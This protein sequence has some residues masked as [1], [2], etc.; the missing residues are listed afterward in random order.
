M[1]IPSNPLSSSLR[2]LRF[3]L[4]SS[5][6]SS[7]SSLDGTFLGMPGWLVLTL[8]IVLG[9]IA[10][11]A[12]AALIYILAR[13]KKIKALEQEK[14]ANAAQAT[15]L[16][17]IQKAALTK[18]LFFSNVSHDMR[19]PL[20][21][22]IGYAKLSENE[23]DPEK[24]ADYFKK[25]ENAG[26]LLSDLLN[27]TM[28]LSKIEAGKIE[29]RPEPIDNLAFFQEVVDEIQPAAAAKQIELR[30][31][32]DELVGRTIMADRLDLQKIMLNLL[33]NAVKYTP[34]G[35]HVSLTVASLAVQADGAPDTEIEVKD[36]GIGISADFLPYI[37]EPYSQEQRPGYE[38]S[39]IG[40]GL[41][42]VKTLVENMKGTIT[43]ESIEGKGST[44]TLHFHFPTAKNPAVASSKTTYNDEDLREKK[45]LACEDN[46]LN[47]EVIAGL[48]RSKKMEVTFAENGDLG[49]HLFKDSSLYHF[50]AILMDVRMPVMDGY[51]ASRM[52]RTLDRPDAVSCP[53]IA[54]T[55]DV[56]PVD[57]QHC[58]Q[59]G[60]N[61]HVAKPIDPDKLFAALAHAIALKKAE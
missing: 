57:I 27:D 20:D 29:L 14:E 15:E 61:D 6:N 49:Y 30:L 59:A 51:Q 34:K 32:D 12:L 9:V 42:I 56:F 24:R 35:G 37:F 18:N 58:H 60:M 8:L 44:F 16:L 33:S 45:I 5:A 13:Q 48:L 40:L 41:S 11:G 38:G 25:I 22:M 10:L 46:A 36:D 26:K 23:K 28:E 43:C 19:T 50:D 31:H 17:A 2:E 7:S 3:S 52:I 21:A 39:G 54:L 55:A 47:R 53:I 1:H 4:F